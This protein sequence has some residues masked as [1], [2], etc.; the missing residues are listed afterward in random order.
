ME[1]VNKQGNLAYR[2]VLVSM[3]RLA[4][5]SPCKSDAPYLCILKDKLKNKRY[6]QALWTRVF[7]FIYVYGIDLNI[8]RLMPLCKTNITFRQKYTFKFYKCTFKQ[9]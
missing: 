3:E 5:M 2:M 1:A 7:V 4:A 6:E 9:Q 8:E